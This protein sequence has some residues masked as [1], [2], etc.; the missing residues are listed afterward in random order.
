M[1]LIKFLI[2]LGIVAVLFVGG[3]YVYNVHNETND[4]RGTIVQI[5]KDAKSIW[6]EIEEYNPKADVEV[7]DE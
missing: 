2:L 3:D 7:S 5:G 4:V 1:D 6:S